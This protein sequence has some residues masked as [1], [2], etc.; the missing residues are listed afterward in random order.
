ML[1]FFLSTVGLG[2][3]QVQITKDDALFSQGDLADAIFYLQ[4]GRVK[5]TV[6]SSS[7]KEATI[8]IFD[9]GSFIGEEAL[10]IAGGLRIATCTAMSACSCL[11]IERDEMVRVMH[12]EHAFS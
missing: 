1:V 6:V 2:R 9:A 8:A 12:A 10:A 5:H 4:K 3:R 11:K 7:G